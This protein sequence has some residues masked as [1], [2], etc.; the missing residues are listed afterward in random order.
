[1]YLEKANLAFDFDWTSNFFDLRYS[2]MDTMEDRNKQIVSF[3]YVIDRFIKDAKNRPAKHDIA[4]WDFF[5][6]CSTLKDEVKTEKKYTIR[7]WI[8]LIYCI[9]GLITEGKMTKRKRDRLN[10]LN[11]VFEDLIINKEK[12]KKDDENKIIEVGRDLISTLLSQREDDNNKIDAIKKSV[13][14]DV[15]ALCK[16]TSYCYYDIDKL[17]FYHR[18]LKFVNLIEIKDKNVEYFSDIALSTIMNCLKNRYTD[19]SYVNDYESEIKIYKNALNVIDHL[20]RLNS[21][22][23][24]IACATNQGDYQLAYDA[25]TSWIKKKSVGKL[26]D[27]KLCVI[28]YDTDLNTGKKVTLRKEWRE[29]FERYIYENY[30]EVCKLIADYY[31]PDTQIYTK[32]TDLAIFADGKIPKEKKFLIANDYLEIGTKY[33]TYNNYEKAIEKID[34]GLESAK[35]YLKENRRNIW[36]YQALLKSYYI[37]F[38]A[39]LIKN[40]GEFDSWKKDKETQRNLRDVHK[41]IKAY[42]SIINN[43]NNYGHDE[44]VRSRRALL[45]QFNMAKKEKNDELLN[46][47]YIVTLIDGLSEIITKSLRQNV[48]VDKIFYTREKDFDNALY[49]GEKDNNKIKKNIIAYYTTLKN[50][51]Y[52]F[53]EMVL[54]KKDNTPRLAEKDERGINCLTVMNAR[55]MN[56]PF[57]GVTIIKS[58]GAG[59]LFDLS[60]PECYRENVLKKQHVFLKSFTDSVD[61]LWMWNRYASDYDSDGKNSNGCCVELDGKMF[62]K[63]IHK[64]NITDDYHLYKIIYVS[65]NGKIIINNNDDEH[66]SIIE[67]YKNLQK[68]FKELNNSVKSPSSNVDEKEYEERKKFFIDY[69]LNTSFGR[70]MFLVKDAAYAD[71]HESRMVIRRGLSDNDIRLLGPKNGSIQKLGINP[72]SQV[73]VKKITIGPNTKNRDE[74]KPYLQYKL[75]QMWE[76]IEEDIEHNDI[77]EEELW[78]VC[79]SSIQ[80]NTL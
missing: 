14:K 51:T 32:Y 25:G 49:K 45:K 71:E 15:L 18:T 50:V 16:K 61:K 30:S 34:L 80:Y 41:Y 55:Y 64:S 24:L 44:K 66:E 62:D 11:A 27:E 47:L 48:Y 35:E 8:S 46:Q 40:N 5:D 7:S 43:R 59:N 79:D 38:V 12:D 68:L 52:L 36:I 72:Y 9:C 2:Y 65:D 20:E 6:R 23:R 29:Y 57:E 77:E 56:D 60:H 67:N 22:N 42:L 10:T 21:F 78:E 26:L 75:N 13:D 54:D 1:M 31:E 39:L 58:T 76:K 37:K 3:D 19:M 70:L 53:D 17:I 4:Y 69:I 28:N 63:M 74:W 33:L 73:Y